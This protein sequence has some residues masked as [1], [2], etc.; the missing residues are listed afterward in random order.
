MMNDIQRIYDLIARGQACTVDALVLGTG[1]DPITVRVRIV[2]LRKS[3]RITRDRSVSGPARYIATAMSEPPKAYRPRVAKELQ[4]RA[5]DS[6]FM[7]LS[8]AWR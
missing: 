5:P 6:G 7:A 2:W 1:L 4:T 3:G 8:S